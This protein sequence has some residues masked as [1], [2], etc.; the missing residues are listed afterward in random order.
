MEEIVTVYNLMG[1]Q[2]RKTPLQTP[3]KSLTN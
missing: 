2:P 3:D 1:K